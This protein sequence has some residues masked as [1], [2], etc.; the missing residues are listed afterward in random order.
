MRSPMSCAGEPCV[1]FFLSVLLVFVYLY[2]C[3][4]SFFGTYKL[5]P[6]GSAFGPIPFCV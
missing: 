2:F 5:E 6:V 4:A 1:V 3:V